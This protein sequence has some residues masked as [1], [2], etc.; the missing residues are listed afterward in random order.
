M[1]AQTPRPTRR[2]GLWSAA[3]F[4][5]GAAIT[6]PATAYA[7][8]SLRGEILHPYL[9]PASALL[10]PLS[11][12]VAT[13]PGVVNVGIVALTNGVIYAA[14]MTVLAAVLPARRRRTEGSQR[15]SRAVSVDEP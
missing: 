13:W 10:R 7:L 6:V 12:A 2:L 3:G 8:I 1:N 14:V 15:T 5:L 4:L 11:E 9:V